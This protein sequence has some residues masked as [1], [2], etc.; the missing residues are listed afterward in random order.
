MTDDPNPTETAAPNEQRATAHGGLLALR[1]LEGS[2]IDTLF[3]LSGGHIFPLLDAAHGLG[4]RIVDTRHEQT[5]VFAAEAM[6]KVTRTPGLAALTAGPGVTNG[7]S[8]IT[9]AH[10]NGTPLLVLGGRAPQH[11]WGAGSLQELDHVPIVASVTK[12]ATTVTETEEIVGTVRAAYSAA[13]T[14]H[15]GPVF[16]DL[17]LDVVGAHGALPTDPAP[18]PATPLTPDP[19]ALSRAAELLSSAER[20]ICIAGGD[21]YWAH[22]EEALVAFAEAARV[23]VLVNGLGRGTI[24]ADHELAFARARPLA[25]QADVVLVIGTPLDFRL[26]FGHFGD[27]QVIHAVDAPERVATHVEVAGSIV[28][29]LRL[30]LAALADTAT[31]RADHE[32][33]IARLRDEE[34][35]RRAAERDE[36]DSDADPIH[37]SR[38]YGEL[39]R[40]L[41][42]DAVVIGDGGDFVS[43]A[44]RFVDSYHPGCFLEPGPYGCL[45]TGM[46][47][48]MAARLAHPNRQVVVCFGDGAFGF[49][50]MD[51]DTLVRHE[52]PVVMVVGNN[53][54]WGLEKHPMQFFYGYDV[55]ADL[56]PAARYDE[57]VAALGG[58]GETVTAPGEIGPA[59]DRAFASGVPYL[60]NVV[61]DPQIAYPRS[62][63]LA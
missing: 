10:L 41:D 49:S 6:A 39:N 28:G 40:R 48:A 55:A 23:P 18:S 42:R 27:A 34:R 60:V 7:V 36:L 12:W 33:W 31:P 8:A 1:A 52:L 45:G 11:R 53:G 63:N 62:S 29:D 59:L 3:T 43:Y 37:P 21:V 56:Q 26:S 4:W 46:G 22:G 32:P 61:T 5:A 54:I 51:V 15:R 9:G 14:P 47:Y 38:V 30:V 44:G 25:K 50:G 57:V 58:A 35:A 2:G 13:T 20:P 16:V 17:P 24:P 19:D